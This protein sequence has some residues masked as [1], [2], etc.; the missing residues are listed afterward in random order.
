[1]LL[2]GLKRFGKIGKAKAIVALAESRKPPFY[3][4][5]LASMQSMLSEQ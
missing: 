1:M 2:N 3:S 5:Y 4:A